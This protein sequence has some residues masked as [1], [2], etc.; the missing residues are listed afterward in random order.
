VKTNVDHVS[1]TYA[2][3][4]AA[5]FRHPGDPEKGSPVTGGDRS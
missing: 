2:G 1:P 4:S 5:S 3:S